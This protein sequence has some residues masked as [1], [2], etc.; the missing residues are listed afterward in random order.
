MRLLD[1]S[2]QNFREKMCVESAIRLFG[3][4]AFF[5]L[6]R[7]LLGRVFIGNEEILFQDG[8]SA[9]KKILAALARIPYADLHTTC[10]LKKWN[11]LPSAEVPVLCVAVHRVLWPAVDKQVVV[12]NREPK[13][14]RDDSV[15]Y[16]LRESEAL[17]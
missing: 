6:E 1:V 13:V 8:K 16:V 14:A 17:D 4:I 12:V 11:V 15:R 7:N 5:L 2:T 9:Q 10:T 3:S